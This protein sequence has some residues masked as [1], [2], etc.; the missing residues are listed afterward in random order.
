MISE[1][2]YI[3][4][5]PVGGSGAFIG[6]S[7][8]LR[9]VL[10]TLRHSC[11][12]TLLLYGQR[13]IG[14]TSVLQELKK[15]LPSE[16][17]YLPV[18]FDLQDKA[19]L[20]V[21]KLLQDLAKQIS[22]DLDLE[23]PELAEEDAEETFQR[24][25]LPQVMEK[26]SSES[27]I[28]LLLDEFDVLDN[29]ETGKAG[30]K[31]FPYLRNLLSD[32]SHQLQFVFVIGRRPD[33]LT[34]LINSVFK[35]TRSH[36][37]SLLSPEDTEVLV[38]LS[39]QNDS[40]RWEK[41]AVNQIHAL[42]GG[43]PLLTQQLCQEIWEEHYQS[44]DDEAYIPTVI[45][46]HVNDSVPAALSAARQALEWLWAGLEP[47]E[48][49]VAAALAEA[50]AGIITQEDLERLLQESGV[51]ILLGELQNAPRVLQEWDLIIEEDGGFRFRVEILRQWI[52]DRKPLSRVQQEIDRIQPMAE[53]LFS[54][55]EQ[56][57][58]QSNF[59]PAIEWLQQA[60]GF[61][62]NHLK[63]NQLLGDI[64]LAQ[65]RL[66]DARKILEDLYEYYPAAAKPRL[67][68]VLLL[69]VSEVQTENEC[70]AL[71]EQILDIDPNHI[72]VRSKYQQIWLSRGE[73]ALALYE[74]G[75]G[76]NSE[77]EVEKTLEALRK[78]GS[79]DKIKALES[80]LKTEY[81]RRRAKM[82][83]VLTS[84]HSYVEAL[85]I[86]EHLYETYIDQVDILPNLDDLRQKA[87]LPELY[88][89]AEQ[90]I[91]E[92]D[93][94]TAQRLL[95]E[96]ATVEPQYKDTV[97]HLYTIVKGIDPTTLSSIVASQKK[98]LDSHAFELKRR[99]QKFESGLSEME[100][101]R[102]KY[103]DHIKVLQNENEN[104]K[105]ELKRTQSFLNSS[106]S[107]IEMKAREYSE[108]I[109]KL[110]YENQNLMMKLEDTQHHLKQTQHHLKHTQM[111]YDTQS[112]SMPSRHEPSLA[113]RSSSDVSRSSQ[114]TF[115]T[116]PSVDDSR[117]NT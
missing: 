30:E 49:V 47:A 111:K 62:P 22:Q 89:K 58:R 51:R 53:S 23:V 34:N 9:E 114:S 98:E 103:S 117:R 27:R 7:D 69:Q 65:R 90:A 48:R 6:R 110:E 60:I 109:R 57:Y 3:A 18:Y 115:H 10:R 73:K 44:Q 74:K 93:H 105:L 91:L 107:E 63:A 35:G 70:L 4:G 66:K 17:A 94:P 14:K 19:V 40:L 83:E 8:V 64:F 29:P 96:I 54:V 92:K 55:A 81:V 68:Q 85:E 24:I 86:A 20:S 39:E 59:E 77:E 43:H 46:D 104:L 100:K 75:E 88:R 32:T 79:G 41:E 33:D 31:F 97:R 112:Y 42:T 87:V 12:N 99:E 113:Q 28:V 16:G 2:P 67:T 13:R 76:K 45:P 95:V 84:R 1:N 106:P 21:G 56:A 108:H 52:A 50:G 25:F 37:V 36:S 61:N 26:F 71:Y 78:S 15:R 11:N 101:K 116:Q 102:R 5:N 82:I 72:E 38:R 80:R